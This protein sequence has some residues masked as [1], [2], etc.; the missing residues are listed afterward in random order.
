MVGTLTVLKNQGKKL[1]IVSNSSVDYAELLMETSFGD[2]WEELFD[3]CMFSARKP[4]FQRA[5]SSFFE[6]DR[7]M[8][9]TGTVPLKGHHA[10]N[11]L[12]SL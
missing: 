7:V 5:K 1:F 9:T 10:L 6:H 11:S 3:W 12:A 8:N 4:L 2:D